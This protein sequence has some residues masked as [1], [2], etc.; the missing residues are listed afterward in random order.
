MPLTMSILELAQQYN[1][2]QMKMGSSETLDWHEEINALFSEDFT[3]IANGN[4]L[5]KNRSE[6]QEQIIMCRKG[7]GSWNIT[8]TEIIPSPDNQKCVIG[9]MLLTKTVSFDVI[10]ILSSQNNQKIDSIDEI[11][12][13]LS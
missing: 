4:T 7:F 5:V 11:Y 12:C 3:K 8:V 1:A 9:Y 13:E 2:L 6:L 10:A